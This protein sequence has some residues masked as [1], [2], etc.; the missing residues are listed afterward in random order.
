[1]PNNRKMVQEECK[2]NDQFSERLKQHLTFPLR[3]KTVETLQLNIIRQC[4]L[5]CR[6]CHVE[7]SPNRDEVM[8]EETMELCLNAASHPSITTIDITG[9][10]PELHPQ[11]EWFLREASAMHKRLLL[12][13]NAAILMDAT[14]ARFFDIYEQTGAE[15][16]VSLPDLHRDRTDRMRG[17]GVFDKII[18]ALQRLNERGY[19]GPNSGRVLDLVHNP[20]GAFLPGSQQAL[21][22]S[23]R[24]VLQRDFGV[25]FNHLFCLA[26][27][28]VGRYLDFLKRSG[29]LEQYLESLVQAFN[30]ITLEHVMCR[31]TISVDWEGRLFD[32]DFNQ[33]LHM[34]VSSEMP[35]H[36]RD[37]DYQR[38]SHREIV[39]RNHCFCCTA[40]EG[41]SCQGALIGQN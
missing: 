9:G 4:N 17:A 21:E 26:N 8:S 23:Y 2:Q 12:R 24:T 41:S 25:V 32:C 20:V 22:H 10:A 37:F 7:G 19:G 16:V 13:T 38:L 28:P 6:H 34:G 1:M 15:L 3:A 14:N 33:V 27:C 11:L 29:N 30:P 18:T 39:V 31:S 5:A 35:G 36:I 40:G